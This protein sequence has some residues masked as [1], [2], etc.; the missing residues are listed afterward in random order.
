MPDGTQK[1]WARLGAIGPTGGYE[2]QNLW[3]SISIVIISLFLPMKQI[4]EDVKWISVAIIFRFRASHVKSDWNK[5]STFP[6]FL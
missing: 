1:M 2:R 5:G 4:G 3:I 6:D